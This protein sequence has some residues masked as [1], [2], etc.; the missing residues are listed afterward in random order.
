MGK[1]L[2]GITIIFLV[3]FAFAVPPA[4]GQ[5][6]QAAVLDGAEFILVIENSVDGRIYAV[7]RFGRMETTELGKV[8]LPVS[9]VNPS[10][11]TASGW[12]MKCTV[13]ATAVNAIHLKVGQNPDTGRGKI[14]S[15]LPIEFAEFD[16]DNYNSYFNEEASL[17]TRISAGTELFGGGFAP[18]VGDSILLSPSL[19]SPNDRTALVTASPPVSIPV[20]YAGRAFYRWVPGLTPAV[21]DIIV[22]DVR[23][24]GS[25][26]IRWIEFDNKFG[27]L[28]TIR[29]LESDETVTIGQ[30]YQP[31]F[32]VGR[33]EGSLFLKQGRIRANHP[34]VICISTSPLGE[35]GGFQIIPLEHA[36]SPEMKFA[37]TLTQWMVVG[38]IDPRSSQEWEGLVPLFSDNIYPSFVPVSDNR[39]TAL[40]TLM[41]RFQVIVKMKGSD[42]WKLMPAISGRDDEALL[43]VERMRILFPL[44]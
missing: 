22:M 25:D 20:E 19:D 7:N 14:F 26:R 13:V 4:V 36:M 41:S 32:G 29:L 15:I 44:D 2:A 21:G 39:F 1:V 11:F 27:G 24:Q 42:E 40:D 37:R 28:I 12:G 35:I 10:G 9:T 30:V 23:P 17:F 34:G 5:D 16:S 6:E 43:N 38:P 33:F 31:A 18:K 8:L 3:W